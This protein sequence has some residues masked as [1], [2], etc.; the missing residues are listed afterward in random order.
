MTSKNYSKVAL[1]SILI[2][3]L[4]LVGCSEEQNDLA[5]STIDVNADGGQVELDPDKS[6]YKIGDEVKLTASPNDQF[7][8]W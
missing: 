1:V 3:L 6:V 7:N 4:F 2:L 5:K 8:G